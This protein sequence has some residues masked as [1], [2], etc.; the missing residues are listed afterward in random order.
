MVLTRLGAQCIRYMF[1]PRGEDEY[2][3]TS[4][5]KL[6]GYLWRC[7]VESNLDAVIRAI[8]QVPSESPAEKGTK[9]LQ[10]LKNKLLNI[11]QEL[12]CV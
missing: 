5:R 11:R 12:E 4:T 10:Y 1:G 2:N 8:A 6:D 9:Q 3:D 7:Y